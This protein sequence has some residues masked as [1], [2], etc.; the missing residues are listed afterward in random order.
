V[1]VGLLFGSFNPVHIGHLVIAESVLDE[2]G[3]DQVWLVVSPQNPFKQQA[4]LLNEYERYIMCE[5]ATQTHDRLFASN[6]E[7]SLPRPSYTIDTLTHLAAHYPRYRFSVAMGADTLA[8][9][10]RWKNAEA[11]VRWYR[12]IAYPRA[13]AQ[14]P[15]E[16]AALAQWIDAPLL[17]L[18]ATAV[19]QR[20]QRGKSIRYLVPE[21]VRLYIEARCLYAA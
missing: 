4:S 20:L 13:G 21:E 15:A 16:L 19:R 8:T 10:P 9:V 2:A 1:N 14:V 7:F 6:V 5:L 3:L 17:E 11:L 18:S 12:L